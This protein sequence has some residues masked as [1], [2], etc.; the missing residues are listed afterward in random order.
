MFRKILRNRFC[1]T[2]ACV[3]QGRT[4]PIAGKAMSRRSYSARS[5]GA[6]FAG[7][8]LGGVLKN[9]SSFSFL[10]QLTPASSSSFLLQI[11]PPAYSRGFFLQFTPLASA[12]PASSSSFLIWLPL[13]ASSASFLLQ[14]QNKSKKE[15][16]STQNRSRRLWVVIALS[17]SIYVPNAVPVQ[18]N[19]LAAGMTTQRLGWSLPFSGP[20]YVPNAVP[21]QKNTLSAPGPIWLQN[22]SKKGPKLFKMVHAMGRLGSMLSCSTSPEGTVPPLAYSSSLLLCLPPRVSSPSF[23]LWLPPPASYGFLLRF[24][25]ASTT[26]FPQR[27]FHSRFNT[28]WGLALESFVLRLGTWEMTLWRRGGCFC[29]GRG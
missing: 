12:P 4:T 19:A 7:H 2:N 21:V 29:E 11:S 24:P 6:G 1:G 8:C 17:G 3:A 28:V 22:G 26:K 16:N 27:V 25:P 9:T 5:C 10:C 14:V 15:P 23:H 20:I 13:P 18:K